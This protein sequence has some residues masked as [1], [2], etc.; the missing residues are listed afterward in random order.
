MQ[1]AGDI[2]TGTVFFVTGTANATSS[3]NHHHHYHRPFVHHFAYMF[4][5]L[6]G[7]K[8]SPDPDDDPRAAIFSVASLLLLLFLFLLLL[9]RTFRYLRMKSFLS[10]LPSVSPLRYP[11]LPFLGNL[12]DFTLAG[13]T[14][15]DLMVRWHRVHGPIYRFIL[16][17]RD[18]VSVSSPAMLRQVLQTNVA[19]VKKDVDFAYKPFLSILG[20]GIVTSEGK[21]WLRQ[22]LSVGKVL[23]HEILDDIPHITLRMVRRLCLTLDE[24]AASQSPVEISELLRHLTLQVI[25]NAFLGLDPDESDGTFAIMYL[26]IVDEGN[27]RVWAPHRAYM[28]W[29]PAFW[30]HLAAVRRLNGYVSSLIMRRWEERRTSSIEGRRRKDV[31]DHVLN[32]YKDAYGEDRPL[33]I[34]V[35]RQVR[36][37]MKTFM[38]AGHETS[39]AMMTWVMYELIKING[40]EMVHTITKEA[41]KVFTMGKDWCGGELDE[42]IAALPDRETLGKLCFS[43]GCLKEALRKYSVVPTVTRQ[44]ITGTA[45]GCHML[46]P[47]TTVMIGIQ[48][49]HHDPT[50]WKDPES[51]QPS[52]F[53]NPSP[54]P[55]PYTFIPFID[56]PRNCLGQ[57]LALLESKMVLSLLFQRYE[58]GVPGEEENRSR[59]GGDPRHLFMVPIIPKDDVNLT[60]RRRF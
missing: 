19:G 20:T 36:D 12:L 51:Y 21:E 25:S 40:S 49:I 1:V 22:R 27:R 54:P 56:G 26:P 53:C 3:Q 44:I 9:R 8:L 43:E 38:L 37:E 11:F 45:V 32:A 14:P 30:R 41:E 46:P 28:V 7:V 35:L 39:A 58:F 17:G 18:C 50:I 24:A 6:S 10:T 55:K 5:T 4:N 33:P 13:L 2:F 42:A 48:S 47:G 16:L 31:L 60:V 57:Y 34:S 59:E 29:T 52:R 23:R 15:W